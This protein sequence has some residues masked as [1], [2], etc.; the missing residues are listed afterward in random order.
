MKGNS[1]EEIDD[2]PSLYPRGRTEILPIALSVLALG[3]IFFLDIIVSYDAAVYHWAQG[4]R[5]CTLDHY[6]TVL[7]NL[8]LFCLSLLGCIA[9]LSICMQRNW[10]EACYLVLVVVIGTFLCEVLKTGFERARPSVIPSILEG[11]SYPSGHVVGAVLLTGTLLLLLDRLSC[12]KWLKLCGGGLLFA[13]TAMIIWQ[14]IYLA[15]HWL[16]DIIGSLLLASAWLLFTLP[17]SSYIRGKRYTLILLSLGFFIC[18]QCFYF[19]PQLRGTLLSGHYVQ[20]SPF[21]TFSFGS[22]APPGSLNG[23][24]EAHTREP[25]GP[26]SWA[27]RG[28]ANIALQLSQVSVDTLQFIARPFIE[29]KEFACYPVEIDING[30][31]AARLF[32]HRGWRMYAI[33]LRQDWLHLG[34]NIVTFR[35]NKDFPTLHPEQRTV[36]LNTLQAVSKK[37]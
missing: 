21:L 26:I 13:L 20:D 11:N 24:W 28:E 16:S 14:R 27:K 25:L 1:L 33:P 15:H 9:L 22:S 32:L 30:Q 36:A 3:E 34:K 31:A 23:A 5:S 8:P 4:Q 19:F 18:Y 2:L 12:A 17:T 7:K 10:T 37:P 6:A 35:T 29:S